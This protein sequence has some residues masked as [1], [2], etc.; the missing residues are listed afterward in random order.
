MVLGEEHV[1]LRLESTRR[2]VESDETLDVDAAVAHA[3]HWA[4]EYGCTVLVLMCAADRCVE[5]ARVY[6]NGHER[7]YAATG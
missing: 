1:E 7:R 6:R 3:H 5:R 2:V 4:A